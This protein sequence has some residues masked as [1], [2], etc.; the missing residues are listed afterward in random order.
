MGGIELLRGVQRVA[1]SRR[2]RSADVGAAR[3]LPWNCVVDAVIAAT[4]VRDSTP[5][6]SKYPLDR[7]YLS[8][9]LP[10][11]RKSATGLNPAAHSVDVSNSG[12]ASEWGRRDALM[13][14]AR[15][16]HGFTLI[17]IMVVVAIVGVV[18]LLT[19]IEMGDWLR[20]QRI[21]GAARSAADMFTIARAEAIR[22]GSNH[23]VFFGAPGATDTNGTALI[24]GSGSWV[25]VLILDD[26]APATANCK[27]DSGETRRTILPVD[28]VTWGVAKATTA[29]PDDGH[30]ALFTAPQSSGRT[31]ADA[32]GNAVNWVMFRP[33]GI[34]VAMSFSA[35]TCGSIGPTGSGSAALYITNGQR[36]YAVVLSALGAV[37]VHRWE[38]SA[39]SS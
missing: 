38:G 22:T 19:S 33:D 13:T 12:T 24:N 9:V 36:D 14:R 15:N 35:G 3:S 23:I 5:F 7:R 2:S 37:R 21:K 8:R 10:L 29:A 17:E 20:H 30:S 26:G 18:A 6:A 27:I 39:W 25:P 1:L 31:F 11:L 32:A 28:D 34:P 16:T 4:N